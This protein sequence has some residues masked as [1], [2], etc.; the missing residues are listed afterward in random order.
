M[1]TPAQAGVS[2]ADRHAAAKRSTLVSVAVNVVLS[3]LQIVLGFFAHSQSLIADGFHSLSDLLADFVVLAANRVSH[4]AADANHP[5]GHARFET[6]AS[7]LLGL[8]LLIV[9]IGMLWS[10]GMKMTNPELIP[11]VH[12]VALWVALLTLLCK[13]GLFRYMLRVAESVKSSMLVANAWHARSD[14]ASSLVVAVGIGGNLMG[15]RFL[16]PLAAALVG[17]MIGRSGWKFAWS[18]L[19]DLMDRGLS[20]HEVDE[21]RQTLAATPGVRN[22]HDLRTRHM[23]DYALVDAHL[24]VD[25]RI[26][27]SE[28]HYI[29]ATARRRVLQHHR[30]LDVLVHIDPEDDEGERNAYD[31]PF[32]EAVMQRLRDSLGDSEAGGFE[33]QLHYLGGWLDLD[34]VLDDRLTAPDPAACE[35]LLARLKAALGE[36]AQIRDIRILRPACAMPHERA[37]D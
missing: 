11:T 33:I 15:Y 20:D 12:P 7:M 1:S 35:Q 30:A 31:L 25:G 14:A 4:E 21:I 8:L 18:A 6:A 19:S 26:S 5:Y 37:D 17:F 2:P 10:A 23:G 16:D 22:V 29:A 9:G 36:L 13:E 28:G 27:V 32:R 34:I 3:T 24:L